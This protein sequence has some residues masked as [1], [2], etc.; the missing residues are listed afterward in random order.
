MTTEILYLVL[1][2]VSVL[3]VVSIIFLGLRSR[4]KPEAKPET[5]QVEPPAVSEPVDEM[6][7]PPT[8]PPAVDTPPP[9][10]T[11]PPPPVVTPPPMVEA[12][13]KVSVAERLSKGLSRSRQALGDR[14]AQVLGKEKLTEEDWD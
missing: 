14:L 5:L 11:P 8:P 2:G 9:V 12:P 3:I 7:I 1:A 4:T 13:P 6:V 10:V